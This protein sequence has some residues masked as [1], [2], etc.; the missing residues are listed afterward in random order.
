VPNYPEQEA[1]SKLL[2]EAREGFGYPH[3]E[4][5]TKAPTLTRSP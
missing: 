5:P 2:T 1:H 3:T 4:S